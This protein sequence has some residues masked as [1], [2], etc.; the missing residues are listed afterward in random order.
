MGY[1]DLGS[2]V[3]NFVRRGREGSHGFI[4]PWAKLIHSRRKYRG[5][6]TAVERTDVSG[7]MDGF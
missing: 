6:S 5:V 1:K 3:E 7:L 2:E 4:L